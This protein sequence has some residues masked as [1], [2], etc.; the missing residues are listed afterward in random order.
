[1]DAKKSL[2]LLL[3]PLF[4]LLLT[5][6]RIKN[7]IWTTPLWRINKTRGGGGTLKSETWVEWTGKPAGTADSQT[8]RSENKEAAHTVRL[9]PTNRK[10]SVQTK[11][12]TESNHKEQHAHD[13][14][15]ALTLLFNISTSSTW[16]YN[17]LQPP[18][19]L[20]SHAAPLLNVLA[21]PSPPN[22]EHDASSSAT[23]SLL[24][25]VFGCLLLTSL[26][27][28]VCDPARELVCCL[29]FR[30]FWRKHCPCCCTHHLDQI[31]AKRSLVENCLLEKRDV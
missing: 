3:S 9:I 7:R 8:E 17:P 10:K 19:L 6:T 26:L 30:L 31:W 29:S 5:S 22:K 2:S 15:C 20:F 27:V 11:D 28:W 25:A 14:S 16:H 1:M 18:S 24:L 23:V 12:S 4:K 13:T 21:P